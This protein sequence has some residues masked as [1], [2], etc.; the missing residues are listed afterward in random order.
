MIGCHAVVKGFGLDDI[1]VWGSGVREQFEE[2][3]FEGEYVW[4]DEGHL[5][6]L[7]GFPEG[8]GARL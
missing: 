6:E 2:V 5:V 3:V 1:V 4:D 8:V 7:A